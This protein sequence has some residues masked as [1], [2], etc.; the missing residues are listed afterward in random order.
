[1]QC[2]RMGINKHCL[3]CS[4]TNIVVILLKPPF[5]IVKARHSCRNNPNSVRL[6]PKYKEFDASLNLLFLYCLNNEQGTTRSNSYHA[7]ISFQTL[8]LLILIPS[9]VMELH[10][11][12]FFL[13][14]SLSWETGWKWAYGFPWW[15]QGGWRYFAWFYT[16]GSGR[17]LSLV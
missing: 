8:T 9:P 16:W 14:Q 13:L 1:M 17:A 3:D 11:Q 7:T 5:S 6:S 4:G 2:V 12:T 15:T 10:Q